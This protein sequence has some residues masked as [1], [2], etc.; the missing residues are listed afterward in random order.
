MDLLELAERSRKG[1]VPP[2]AVAIT[3]DDGYRDNYEYAF[4][5]LKK[6]GLTAT[7]FVAT[8]V[9]GSSNLLWHDRMF[10]AFRYTTKERARVLNWNLPEL[11][12]DSPEKRQESVNSVRAR[13]RTLWGDALSRFTD[14]IE[15]ALRP[16]V[17]SGPPRMLNWDQI[18]E[19][20]RAGIAFGSHTVTHPILSFLPRHELIVEI[21]DSKRHLEEQLG[22]PI[23]TF[24]YPNGQVA[25]F[26]DEAKAVLQECGYRCAVTTISGFNR[27]L[28]DPFELKRYLP[29]DSEIEL[30]RFKFFLQRHGLYN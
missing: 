10:D 5:I 21:G 4:P 8:G 18:K 3:F 20:H 9:T 28:A 6:Y 13:A 1:T 29:W 22:E 2:G 17:P 19:M 15:D 7:I 14:D 12:L 11:I 23:C 30:F 26:G 16:Q 27:N 25:D 24:A